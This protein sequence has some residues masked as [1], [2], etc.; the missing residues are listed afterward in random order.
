M[1]FVSELPWSS[2]RFVRLRL[3][4]KCKPLLPFPTKYTHSKTVVPKIVSEFILFLSSERSNSLDL[5]LP[6]FEISQFSQ[7]YYRFFEGLHYLSLNVY[8]LRVIYSL[9]YLCSHVCN[10]ESYYNFQFLFTFIIL[11]VFYLGTMCL[12]LLLI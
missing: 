12:A 11:T 9:F 5:S 7:L 4:N 10:S 2:T 1:S 6:C 8:L 3:L